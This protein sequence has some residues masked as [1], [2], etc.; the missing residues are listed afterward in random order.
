MS[1]YQ[2]IGAI[3]PAPIVKGFKKQTDYLGWNTQELT[4]VGFIFF[5]GLVLSAAISANIYILFG[6]PVFITLPPIFLGFG[7][8]IYFW[9]NNAA[10]GRGRFVERILPDVLQLVS[11]NMKSGL[12]TE[13]ALLASARPE[14][15]AF[16]NELKLAGGKILA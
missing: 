7:G 14:F 11:S 10:E 12:T 1:F 16:G 8:G 6:L 9:L 2:R 15:G 4:V 5:F 13:R 3:I